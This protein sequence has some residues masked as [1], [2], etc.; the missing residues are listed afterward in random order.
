MDDVRS[1]TVPG[2]VTLIGEHLDHNG[3][4][5]LPF[6]VD[7]SLRVRARARTDATVA[8]WSGGRTAS[9]D[10]T[11]SP[12]DGQVTADDWASYVAGA[13][14][15]T[16]EA[17]LAHGGLD[18]VVEGDLP[19][20]AGLASS[21][22]ITC[23]TVLAMTDVHG[24]V[25]DRL[26]VAETA[27]RAESGYIGVPVGLMDQL[28]VLHGAPGHGVLIDH[29]ARP[30]GV[31]TVPLTWAD[32]DLALLVV[33]TRVRHRLAAGEY[34]VR[35]EECARAAEALGLDHL[36][37]AGLDAVLTLE[38]DV[39]VRRTKHVLTETARVRAAV[40]ALRTRSWTQLGTMLTASHT[41]LRD[42]F[43][44]SCPE[45]DDTVDASLEAG[46]LGARMVG[47]G[48]GGSAIALVPRGKAAAVRTAVEARFA[49]RDLP[50]PHVAEVVPAAGARR[51]G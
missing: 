24:Q 19:G 44:V 17:G 27:Q 16:R 40:N 25:P 14:W 4:P 12:G 36:A 23:A 2:R 37:A 31:T 30:P 47:G 38:D 5:T 1:W 51:A 48:F 50:A 10:V 41:S 6:A 39:L 7:R 45:L 32:D 9:F 18:L 26:T 21:A 33:D 8:V 13:V 34:A 49:A 20:G 3:G 35:R 11:V 29:A 46:A 43:E 28:A 22:A 15:A 42:D